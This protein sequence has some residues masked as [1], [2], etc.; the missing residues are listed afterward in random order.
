MFRLSSGAATVASAVVVWMAVGTATADTVPIP[1]DNPSFEEDPAPDGGGVFGAFGWQIP[2]NTLSTWN[3]NNFQF[4]NTAGGPGTLPSPADGTQCLMNTMSVAGDDVFAIQGTVATPVFKL[5]PH[6]TYTLTAAFGSPLDRIMDGFALG[7]LDPTA[8]GP[9]EEGE[10]LGFPPNVPLVGRDANGDLSPPPTGLWADVSFSV[11]S[12]DYIGLRGVNGL[13][14]AGDNMS[15]MIE[16]GAGACA[17]NVRLTATDVPEPSSLILQCAGALVA[18]AYAWRAPRQR[19][20]TGLGS[21]LGCG[22][23]GFA[24]GR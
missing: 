24:G 18:L 21:F 5:L 10:Y 7:F 6:K 12:D 11:N 20:P 1:L 15:V 4:P 8:G 2:P 23:M 19:V 13:V 3:P 16:L 17:D 9:V 14:A 22:R